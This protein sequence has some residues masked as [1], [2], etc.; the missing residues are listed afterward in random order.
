[1]S[2]FPPWLAKKLDLDAFGPDSVLEFGYCTELLLRLMNAKVDVNS[3]DVK[4]ISDYLQSIGDS[5]VAVKNGSVIKIHV[6]TMTPYK[7]LE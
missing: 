1:M 7:V 4:T 5:V 2:L 6:H 3:F